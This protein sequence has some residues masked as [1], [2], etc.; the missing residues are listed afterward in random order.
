MKGKKVITLLLLIVL[1]AGTVFVAINGVGEKE[2][3]G[4]NN[5]KL[6]LDLAGGVSITYTTVKDNPSDKELK[7]T[8]FKLRKR[9]DSLGYTE[10]E[11]YREGSDRINVDIPNAKDAE[12]VLEELGKPG[13][14]EFVGPDNVVILTGEDVKD[15][16]AQIVD[17]EAD[18]YIIA[19]ELNESGKDKFAEATKKFLGQIIAIVYNGESIMTPRVSKVIPDGNA[20]ITNMGNMERA[21][22]MAANIRI[23]ALPLELE[24]LRS[25]V[26]GA[27]LGSEAVDTSVKAGI[28]GLVIILLFMLFFYRMPGLAADIALV[29]YAG[30]T[31]VLLSVFKITLTLPGIAGIILSIGMAV[32]ANIIIFSRIK[33]ELALEKTLRSSLKAGF[34]KATSAILD[35]NITTLIAAIVLYLKGTGPIKGFAQTLALGIIVSMFTALVIT[36]VILWAFAGLG[37][38]NK[39]LYGIAQKTRTINVVSRRKLWFGI[40]L[41][42]IVI[43]LISMPIHNASKGT[44]LNYDIEFSGGSTT[45]VNIGKTMTKSEIDSELTP[46]V[47]EATKDSSPQF[48]AVSNKTQVIIKTKKLGNVERSNLK[49]KLIE[50]YGITAEDIES[51]SISATISDDMRR[52]AL[53]SILIATICILL[54]VTLRFKDYRFGV[55]AVVALVHDVLIVLAVYSLFRIPINNSFIAAMLTIVGYSI[56]DTIV[57]FDRVRENQKY[58]KRGDFKGVV[59]T[60]ISQTISRSINTSLTTFIMIAVLYVIGVESIKEFALPLMVGIISGTYS[61]IF[62]ASPLWYIFKRKEESKIQK[63]H[64][65]QR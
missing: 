30:L 19:L 61:S 21:E 17:G 32:D 41:V 25:N 20:S 42:I 43:G 9:I 40:S 64:Q 22:N 62:V 28:I 34:K 65:P 26:V 59:D 27:K 47:V 16:T 53:M 44:M 33:E 37:I 7:D 58:M 4:A 51:T 13:K 15:A 18:P 56:N 8:V 3:G 14:L 5:V 63:A 29:F 60:S 36:R 52:N 24:E 49:D 50:T 48:Q 46:I 39:K 11:V 10:G 45:L 55:S 1:I 6:G 35:G 57:L 2:T 31:V 38:K 23:G 12:K 54:Y